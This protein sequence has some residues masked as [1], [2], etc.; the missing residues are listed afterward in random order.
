M[1]EHNVMGPNVSLVLYDS[2]GSARGA[3]KGARLLRDHGVSIIWRALQREHGALAAG[4]PG[5]GGGADLALGDE[6]RLAILGD[7][8]FQLH[9]ANSLL[10]ESSCRGF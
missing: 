5:R 6:R 2:G 3:R 10:A 9:L 7:A 1:E 8:V 4:K